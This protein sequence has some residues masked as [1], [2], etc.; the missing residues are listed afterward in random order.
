MEGKILVEDV[1]QLLEIKPERRT[2]R[3]LE[4]LG[5][6]MKQLGW[7]HTRLRRGS[8]LRRRPPP[9]I[10]DHHRHTNLVRLASL[11]RADM[12]FGKDNGLSIG[13]KRAVSIAR[14]LQ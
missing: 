1:W 3:Q 10:W 6:A 11:L 9:P 7:K 8:G 2:Q 12:I 13:K 5:D 4:L 14:L